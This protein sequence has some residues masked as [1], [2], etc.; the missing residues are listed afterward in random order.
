MSNDPQLMSE[1]PAS[2]AASG[3]VLAPLH[4]QSHTGEA[5]S[6]AVA[7]RPSIGAPI[8][9]PISSAAPSNSA[10]PRVAGTGA[11][12]AL[13]TA[14]GA[15]LLRLNEGRL[16]E[17]RWFRTDWQRGGAATATARW[18]DECGSIL[19]VVVK[20]PVNLREFRWLRRVASAHD[21][22]V[23]RLVASGDALGPYDFAWVI[24]ERLPHGPLGASWHADHL[25]RICDAAAQ[26]H[27]L[28]AAIPIE[29]LP[30]DEPWEDLVRQARER[31][32]EPSF[33][34]RSRWGNALKDLTKRLDGLV[35]RW[36]ARSPLGWIHGDLH[37]ANA[38][39]RVAS[40]EGPVCLIDFA[41]VR[42]GHWTEDAIYLERLHWPKPDRLNPRPL[43]CLAEA[44][45]REGLDNGDYPPVA[46]IRRLLLAGT[47]PAFRGEQSP[48][49]LGACLARLEEG[50]REVK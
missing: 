1:Q 42:V 27:K 30:T 37:P 8:S 20:V 24:I 25:R 23:A 32:R 9:P 31:A 45:K 39:S 28:A 29:A 44:R 18:M 11:P 14:L 46:A 48:V 4:L 15:E 50:L 35:Q 26:F 36:R 43:K 13:A 38:M 33:A 17:L 19:D 10:S 2:S 16:T 41:E 49:F 40:H 21:G 34:E 3:P 7:A 12:H 22:P 5:P 6:G 47:A